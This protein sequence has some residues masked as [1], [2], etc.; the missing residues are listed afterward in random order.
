MEANQARD[1][2]LKL[3]MHVL[4]DDNPAESVVT[5]W[6][7][8][9]VECGDPIGIFDSFV[10]TPN[11][12]AILESYKD[13]KSPW[14]LGHFYSPLTS[15]AELRPQVDRIY[16]PAKKLNAIPINIEKQLSLLT[17]FKTFINTFPFPDT[18]CEQYRYFTGTHSYSYGDAVVYWSILNYLRPSR[19]IEVGSGSSS[20]LAVDTIK[21]LGLST[22]CTFI[23]PYPGVAEGMLGSLDPAHDILPLRIQ[24]VDLALFE[25]LNEDDL[26][27]IDSTHV[28]KTGS[29][30]LHE[31]TN[32]LPLLKLGTWVHFHDM[33]YNFE[34]PRQWVLD[35]W[36]WNELYAVQLFLMYNNTFEIKLFP[37]HL[38]RLHPQEFNEI[39]GVNTNRMLLNPGGGLWIKK[40]S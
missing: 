37:H 13:G 17:S 16:S 15:R 4:H 28:L 23:D 35:N 34:Y 11:Y 29:D 8:R 38:A 12:I 1:Y 2:I 31:L 33:F 19:I 7:S 32:I 14:P 10:S 22:A 21:Y 3:F 27:F 9:L 36:S 30:V 18:K 6:V 26:L 39:F 20:C 24:D 5:E 25:S 40:V